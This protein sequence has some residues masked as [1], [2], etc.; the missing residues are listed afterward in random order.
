[1]MSAQF[2]NSDN[3]NKLSGTILPSAKSQYKKFRNIFSHIKAEKV[4]LSFSDKK[5]ECIFTIM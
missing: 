2:I 5:I 3:Y 1:M 4:A